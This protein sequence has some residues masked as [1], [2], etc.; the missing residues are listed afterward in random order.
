LAITFDY[1]IRKESASLIDR[2]TGSIKIIMGA[3]QS[4]K[5]DVQKD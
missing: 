1:S 2:E 3:V 4:M 5:R